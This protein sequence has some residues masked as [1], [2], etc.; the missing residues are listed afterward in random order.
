MNFL[1]HTIL[2]AN[3]SIIFYL[4]RTSQ[5]FL[6]FA[7]YFFSLALMCI[8][9]CT[10]FYFEPEQKSC[11]LYMQQLKYNECLKRYPLQFSHQSISGCFS[12]Y[13]FCVLSVFHHIFGGRFFI[14]LTNNKQGTKFFKANFSRYWKLD[15]LLKQIQKRFCLIPF[16]KMIYIFFTH[17]LTKVNIFSLFILYFWSTAIKIQVASIAKIN[18]YKFVE[19]L[20]C[21]KFVL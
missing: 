14:D 13:C 3:N 5:N 12:F 9:S 21:L 2:I 10:K 6:H 8:F 1:V 17:F 16:Y 19:F 15:Y 7:N 18:F 4:K 11:R 20:T